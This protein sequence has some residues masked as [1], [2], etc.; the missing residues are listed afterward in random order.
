MKFALQADGAAAA[1]QGIGNLFKAYVLG[2][3]YRQKAEDDAL[4]S[5]ARM[6]AQ[7]ASA[8]SSLASA[9]KN[10]AAAD[11]DVHQLG[12]QKDPLNTA[13]LELGLPTSLAPAFRQRL[14]TGSFGP[15]YEAPADGVGPVQPPPA[16]PETVAK[17]GQSIALMQRMYG[18]GS[19]VSQGAN[20]ALAD[21]KRY[22]IDNVMANPAL[23]PNAG[24]AFA[25]AEARP[26]F[27]EVGNTGYAMDNFTGAITQAS[28]VL[29]KIFATGQGALANQHNASA[30][31]S[32]ARRERVVAGLDKLVTILDEDTGLPTII[33][34]PTQG[35]PQAL[36]VAVPKG[37][38]ADATNAKARNA[39]IAAVENTP[40][41]AG[42]DDATILTEVNKRLARRGLPAVKSLAEGS[43]KNPPGQPG[44][45]KIPVKDP[46]A[47]EKARA[48]IKAGAPREAVLQRL[49]DNG[50]DTTGL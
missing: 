21:Q 9:R 40:M 24:R 6:A 50:V 48:A 46:A 44:T 31:L 16:A 47:L 38:G 39:V 10:N 3:Q 4:L 13:M 36:G 20:A 41:F 28:P 8:E 22:T 49:K 18:T 45:S 43:D 17:L 23:A 15:S 42:A 19:N 32:N 27:N 25:A 7:R 30:G 26:L 11:L 35:D 29:A 37:T 33:S 34:V 12:L 1:G 2:D 5:G 14:E